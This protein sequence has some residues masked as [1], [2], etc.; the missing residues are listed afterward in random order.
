MDFF[1]ESRSIEMGRIIA[2]SITGT[3]TPGEQAKLD[4]WLQEDGHKAI[5]EELR[6][7]RTIGDA[8]Y[9]FDEFKKEEGYERLQASVRK[10]RSFRL[11][12]RIAAAAVVV[13]A[14]S[15]F[16]TEIG[17]RA[18]LPGK[19]MPGASVVSDISPGGNRAIITLADGSAIALDE[20]QSGIVVG[21]G[22]T[23][24]DGSKVIDPLPENQK[25]TTY[26]ELATPKGG[27]YQVVLSDGSRVWLNAASKLR[28]PDKFADDKRV[29][30]V[31]GE[32]YFSIV[33]DAKRPFR[34]VS[35]QQEVEVLGTEFNISA[36]SDEDECKTTLVNGSVR[37][38][39]RQS[40]EVSTI[41]PGQQLTSHGT[42]TVISQV[43]TSLYTSWKE[44]YFSFK[45]TPIEDVLRQVSRWYDV[46]VVYSNGIP[47]DI[48]G[49]Q[50][51]RDVTL[52][53]LIEILQVS[54][55]DISLQGRV[56]TVNKK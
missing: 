42:K 3:I 8:L 43:E 35:D 54:N 33:K 31:T 37:V 52:L 45:K 19:E 17:Q 34:V 24:S 21:G 47:G 23:Y 27:T 5:Y 56:L 51:R 44:G 20:S 40:S 18:A 14:L 25:S 46:E 38:L 13:F 28:Y 4:N 41:A 55:I 12:I 1:K 49:G 7:G 15:W 9:Q 6:N 11:R 22:V 29:V 50:I 10:G 16:F 32:A 53:G 2:R 36:Y 39:N 30:E 48:F 26:Y